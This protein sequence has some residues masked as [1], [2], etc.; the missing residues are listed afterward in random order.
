MAALLDITNPATVSW[1]QRRLASVHREAGGEVTFLL[2]TGENILSVDIRNRKPTS[3]YRLENV[4][5]PVEK[6]SF[7]VHPTEPQ[8]VSI[9]RGGA[10]QILDLRNTARP[11]WTRETGNLVEFA[12]W[13]HNTG[14][15]YCSLTGRTCDPDV[16]EFSRRL[17]SR[18]RRA[19][20]FPYK[21]GKRNI[22]G[23]LWCPWQENLLFSTDGSQLCLVEAQR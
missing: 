22:T 20:D 1:L 23:S 16:F 15:F 8:L 6:T 3:L 9:C 19:S 2:D 5:V 10:T 21:T 14:K 12:G 13:S 7:A 11:L 4:P 18:I 17:P